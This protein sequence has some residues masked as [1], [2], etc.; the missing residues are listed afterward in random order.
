MK[1]VKRVLLMLL[2]SPALPALR[3]G[4]SDPADHDGRPLLRRRPGRRHRP[5]ARHVDERDAE[6][7]RSSSKTSSA[8][9]ARW[10]PTASPR[11]RPTAT[12]FC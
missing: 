9:A 7:E 8:P 1:F 12:P 4:F 3:R 5:P 11:R 2:L 6:A 10:A